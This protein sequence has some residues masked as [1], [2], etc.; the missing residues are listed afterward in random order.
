[1]VKSV[2]PQPSSTPVT[3]NDAPRL[4]LILLPLTKSQTPPDP[5]HHATPPRR[6]PNHDLMCS[7]TTTPP[8]PPP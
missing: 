7:T 4:Q 1:M 6:T 5:S 2:D 8:P 3:N